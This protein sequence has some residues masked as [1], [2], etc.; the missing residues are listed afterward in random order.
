MPVA[1]TIRRVSANAEQPYP[2]LSSKIRSQ[3]ESP[4]LVH[5]QDAD[6]VAR[7]VDRGECGGVRGDIDEP[8]SRRAAERLIVEHDPREVRNGCERRQDL[9][10]D[11]IGRAHV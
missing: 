9:G 6:E 11:Q 10:T 4:R 7:G 2:L 1:S 3:P 5:L 8:A